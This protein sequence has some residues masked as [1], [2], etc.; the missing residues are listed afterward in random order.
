VYSG[1]AL[2]LFLAQTSR[3]SAAQAEIDRLTELFRKAQQLK[4]SG[5]LLAAVETLE[6]VKQSSA[7]ID[8]LDVIA[9]ESIY[10]EVAL[11]NLDFAHQLTN[12]DQY[13]VYATRSREH[14]RTYVEWFDKLPI[15]RRK[16][17]APHNNRIQ[18]AT[19]Q[20]GRAAMRMDQ[21][22]LMHVD[23]MFL[24]IDYLGSDG[25]ELWKATLQTC[26]LWSGTK[27][28]GGKLVPANLCDGSCTDLWVTFAK[29]LQEWTQVS[30]LSTA[31]RDTYNQESKRLIDAATKCGK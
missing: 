22:Q 21:A 15:D 25:I 13:R 5:K 7:T 8:N 26:P 9:Q 28:P 1:L 6:K 3:S 27:S 29:T 14:W 30:G 4:E 18:K 12:A 11:S 31:A 2:L 23:Y 17:L 10:W 16:S 20:L 19:Y 24:K